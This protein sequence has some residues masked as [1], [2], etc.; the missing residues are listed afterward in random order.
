MS[1]FMAPFASGSSA[2]V[3]QTIPLGILDMIGE[4]YVTEASEMKGS[5]ILTAYTYIIEGK[6][7]RFQRCK[8]SHGEIAAW[9]YKASDGQKFTVF[10]D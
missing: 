2:S 5:M 4:G 9:I 6:V 10:N 8:Y 7:F 3:I 1:N